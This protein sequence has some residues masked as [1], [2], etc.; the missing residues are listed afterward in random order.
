MPP[1]WVSAAVIAAWVA[2]AAWLFRQEL[3]PALEP[4]A[5]PPFTIDLVEE[6]QTEKVPIRWRVTRDGAAV[7]TARTSVSHRSKEN[8]FTLRALFE[9]REGLPE[10]GRKPAPPPYRIRRMTSAYRVTPEGRLLDVDVQIALAEAK[11]FRQT[12]PID[13]DARVW[14][15]VVRGQFRSHYEVE[16]PLGKFA[17][18]LPPVA[19]SS[20]GSVVMPLHPVSRIGG[21]KPGQAWR[22]PVI[23]PL[24]EALGSFAGGGAGRVR[25]LRARVR[26]QAEALRWNGGDTRCLVI[27]YEEENQFTDDR[28]SARTWVREADGLVLKQEAG[29]SGNNWVMT[30]E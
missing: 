26:P 3:W 30:R 6:A 7:L 19:V 25:F 20:R 2:S 13:G 24:G 28:M 11:I 23:D 16:S 17:G 15:E 5:P 14:G 12:I 8:D 1:R 4:D 29:L 21:L 10:P 18:S 22:V 9:P 27:D